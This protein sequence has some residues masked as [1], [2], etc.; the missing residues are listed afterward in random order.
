[1]ENICDWKNCKKI[2]K[3]K[4]PIEKDNSK[5]FRWLCID[6]IKEFNKNWDYFSGMN[7]NEIMQF[8]KSDMTWHKPTQSFGSNDN[9]FKI[10]WNNILRDKEGIFSEPDTYKNKLNLNSFSEKDIQAFKIL[11]LNIGTK[12]P[13]I[14]SK[15]KSLV[16]KFHPDMNSGNKEFENELKKITLAYSLLKKKYKEKNIDA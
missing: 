10:L 16:K 15:F 7:E 11:Q 9:F 5:R 6:H 4:A 14:K 12:W 3:H 8:I 13:I 2:G 1:M